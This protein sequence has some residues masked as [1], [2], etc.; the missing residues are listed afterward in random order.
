MNVTSTQIEMFRIRCQSMFWV[1]QQPTLSILCHL[2]TWTNI[3]DKSN[4]EC[5]EYRIHFAFPFSNWIRFLIS[6][7]LNRMNIFMLKSFIYLFFWW[8]T[9]WNT[10]NLFHFCFVFHC[11]IADNFVRAGVVITIPKIYARCIELEHP[12]IEYYL[13]D[14]LLQITLHLLKNDDNWVRK[15]IHIYNKN[16]KI[17]FIFTWK[18]FFILCFAF[19]F[20]LIFH[21]RSKKMHSVQS[22]HY[23]SRAIYQ[24]HKSKRWFVRHALNCSIWKDCQKMWWRIEVKMRLRFVFIH[25][26]SLLFFSFTFHVHCSYRVV[27]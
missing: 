14:R 2:L 7:A 19:R 5:F 20:C 16:Y 11:S 27:S 26:I 3:C 15:Y 12:E 25:H 24:R 21:R 18:M 23:C 1:C 4:F 9:C 17:R 10:F 8:N 6:L 13:Y 22:K